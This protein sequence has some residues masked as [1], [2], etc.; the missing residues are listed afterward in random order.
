MHNHYFSALWL[1]GNDAQDFLQGQLTADVSKL[2]D[3]RF[4]L[5][6]YCTPQGKVIALCW[7]L[8]YQTEAESGLMLLMPSALVDEVQA[9]LQRFVMRSAVQI[10]RYEAQVTMQT[11]ATPFEREAL[12]VTAQEVGVQ[13]SG[14]GGTCL[15]VFAQ[16]AKPMLATDW[17]VTS[18]QNGIAMI[19]PQTSDGFIPQM[20]G[21]EK[22][23]GISFSKGCYVGQEVV[24]RTHYKSQ[25]RRQLV[26]TL[27]DSGLSEYLVPGARLLHEGRAV[28]TVL[29]YAE[30]AE[31][32]VVQAVIQT[33][34]LGRPLALDGVSN[35]FVFDEIKGA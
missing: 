8:P 21:L 26:W 1:T 32:A 3:E 10:E 7:V 27:S 25:L 33:Q 11:W 9:R 4:C 30:N 20:L 17:R 15:V 14:F 24:A 13:L 29:D 2:G 34:Y 18:I 12:S 22:V 19:Y 6:A 16:S 28:A 23:G 5:S 31:T 35:L